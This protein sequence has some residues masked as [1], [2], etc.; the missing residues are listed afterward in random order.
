MKTPFEVITE[1]CQQNQKN[2]C[3]R[4]LAYSI[5]RQQFESLTKDATLDAVAIQATLLSAGNLTAHV[6]SAEESLRTQFD[7]ELKPIQAKATRDSF[8]F[9]VL[10]GV[11]GNIAYSILL[12]VIFI[13]AKDQLSSWL[14]G[15]LPPR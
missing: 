13:I 5:Y 2:T 3:V 8:W 6:R 11:T 12:I 1:H 4:D 15:L 9:S 14:T 10:T 7:E